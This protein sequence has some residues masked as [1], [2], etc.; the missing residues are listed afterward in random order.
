MALFCSEDQNFL[1]RY[2]GNEIKPI[3]MNVNVNDPSV[4]KDEGYI[5][6]I[7]DENNQ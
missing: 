3:D 2:D 5:R 6:F 1:G 4:G 7:A